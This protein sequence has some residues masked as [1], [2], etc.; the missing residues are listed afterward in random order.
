MTQIVPVSFNTHWLAD[1]HPRVNVSYSA[2]PSNLPQPSFTASTLVMFGRYN[3]LLSCKLYGGSAKIRSTE[4]SGRDLRISIQSPGRIWLRGSVFMICAANAHSCLNQIIP[5]SD[6]AGLW[7]LSATIYPQ[8]VS[9]FRGHW[10]YGIDQFTGCV[11]RI[12]WATPVGRN[13]F[14]NRKR[15]MGRIAGTERD[16]EI[17]AIEID[18]RRCFAA[19]RNHRPA[20][21]SQYRLSASGGA[22]GIERTRT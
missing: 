22:S 20:T 7:H 8:I 2:K 1:S 21:K 15:G 6:S 17:H 14:T 16:G 13:K 10:V 9:Y 4:F 5:S 12:W 18:Q 11:D 3:S 19:Q